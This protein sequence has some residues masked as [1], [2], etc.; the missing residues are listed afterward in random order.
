MLF[1]LARMVLSSLMQAGVVMSQIKRVS[2]YISKKKKNLIHNAL[3]SM[4]QDILLADALLVSGHICR[5]PSVSTIPLEV[6]S[7]V[8]ACFNPLVT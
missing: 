7:A 3:I 2:F 6:A 4:L 5:T 1:Q 8:P